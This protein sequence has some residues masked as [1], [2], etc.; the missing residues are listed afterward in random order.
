MKH[1]GERRP[2]STMEDQGGTARG[3]RHVTSEVPLGD[4]KKCVI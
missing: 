1:D 2:W 3:K 4:A